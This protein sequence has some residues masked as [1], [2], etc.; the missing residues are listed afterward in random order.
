MKQG[1]GVTTTR[2]ITERKQAHE[3][4]LCLKDELAQQA[5]DNYHALFRSM[6]QGFCVL[7]M[8][9]DDTGQHVIG[10]NALEVNPRFA[11]ESGMAAYA[12][13]ATPPEL[14]PALD[15]FWLAAY[16]RVV[17]TGEARRQERYEPWVNRWFDVHAFRIG[18]PAARQVAVLF[19]DITARKQ[20]EAALRESEAQF[21]TVA[22]LVPNLLWRSTLD[23]DTTWYNE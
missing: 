8:L 22:N 17:H 1:D 23:S 14:V 21:R 19:T 5:T 9:F 4:I 2:N 6:Y 10:F 12:T 7:E 3:E 13:G 20:A 11:Q 15:E 18:P 16:G